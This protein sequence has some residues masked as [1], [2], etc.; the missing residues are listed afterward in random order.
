MVC[1][2]TAQFSPSEK[3]LAETE[4]QTLIDKAEI[5]GNNWF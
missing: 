4:M 3:I 2:S 1:R 5:G